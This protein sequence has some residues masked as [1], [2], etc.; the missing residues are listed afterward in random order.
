MNLDDPELFLSKQQ[1]SIDVLLEKYAKGE[2]RGVDDVRRRVARA[3]AAAEQD[4]AHWEG[5]FFA[6]LTAGFI[7]GGRVNSA[8]STFTV[9]FLRRCVRA[10]PAVMTMEAADRVLFPRRLRPIRSPPAQAR[11]F[12]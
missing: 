8:A 5:E 11:Q 4:P 3:L 12:S 1:V 2:E 6:A 10:R 7:P 9:S